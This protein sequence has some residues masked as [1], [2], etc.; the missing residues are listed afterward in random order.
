MDGGLCEGFRKDF[1]KIS[2]KLCK[3]FKGIKPIFNIFK[4][5]AFQSAKRLDFFVSYFGGNRI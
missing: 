4:I 3:T 2:V 1:T 5:F